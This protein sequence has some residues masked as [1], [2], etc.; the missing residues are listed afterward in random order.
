MPYVI[1]VNNEDNSLYGSFKRKIMQREKL[2]NELY[3]LVPQYY[4]GYDMSKCAVTMRYLLPISKEFRT[5]TLKLS[6]EMYEGH[7]KYVLPVDT[8]LTKEWG[9]IKLNLT[10]TMLDDSSGSIVQRVRKTGNHALTIT[11][12]PDWDSF[13]ADES[14][15]AIDQRI[16]QTQAQIKELEYLASVIDSNQVDNLVYNDVDSTLQLSAN[17]MVVGD[18]VIIKSNEAD[19]KDGVP[20]VDFSVMSDDDNTVV[21]EEDNV[22]EF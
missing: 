6:K 13:V 20:V 7:L 8:W 2:F 16:I 14:L 19:L 22:V 1:L 10:F 17:G 4:N 12:L 9:D 21:D 11:R 18:K 15:A 3:F 5:E